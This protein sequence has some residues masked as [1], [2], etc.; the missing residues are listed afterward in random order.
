[1][2]FPIHIVDTSEQT[3]L[4]WKQV[5]ITLTWLWVWWRHLRLDCLLNRLFRRRSKKTSKLRVSDFCEGNSLLTGELPAQMASNAD[6]VSIWWRHHEEMYFVRF[7]LHAKLLSSV[8]L[9]IYIHVWYITHNLS[10][11]SGLRLWITRSNTSF[12]CWGS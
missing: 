12:A 5:F 8:R 1:M 4:F 10:C 6:Y 7:H 2:L 11:I 9:Q 3:S